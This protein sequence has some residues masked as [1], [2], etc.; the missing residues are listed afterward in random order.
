MKHGVDAQ[1]PEGVRVL[2][3]FLSAGEYDAL[4]E[5]CS[6]SHIQQ[7]SST[8]QPTQPVQHSDIVNSKSRTVSVGVSDGSDVGK[9][10]RKQTCTE[11]CANVLARHDN[12]GPSIQQQGGH[13]KTQDTA[14]VC[15][16][17][18]ISCEM[19]VEVC[20]ATASAQTSD[21]VI[22]AGTS[23]TVMQSS[24]AVVQSSSANSDATSTSVHCASDEGRELIPLELYIQ[25]NSQTV[26]MLFL[27]QGSLSELDVI[28]HLACILSCIFIFIIFILL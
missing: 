26:F 20:N 10:S 7:L 2:S 11:D 27:Q 1:L 17:S 13:V 12:S 25:G 16:S 28:R 14:A 22:T 15:E 9:D 6:L 3:V 4:I 23:S 5:R 8:V 19:S 24:T 21:S 18:A